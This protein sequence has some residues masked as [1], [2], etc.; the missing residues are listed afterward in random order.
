MAEETQS[1]VAPLAL[2]ELRR[3][4]ARRLWVNRLTRYVVG[5]GG[6]AV[7]GAI[8]LIF[9]YLLWVVAPVFGGATVDFER[10]L[11][12]TPEDRPL[13]LDVNEGGEIGL[14]I[15]ASGSVTFFDLTTAD[16]LLEFPLENPARAA[17]PVHQNETVYS[18]LDE[19]GLLWFVGASYVIEF[20]GDARSITPAPSFPFD[21]EPVELGD[22]IDFDVVLDDT[23]LV[24]ASLSSGRELVI[25]HYRDVEAGFPLD[26]PRRK[27][28][29][30][31]RRYASVYFG[32]RGKW[33]Y[34]LTEDGEIE[35][36][37]LKRPTSPKSVLFNRLAP[38][39]AEVTVMAPLLGRYSMLVGDNEGGITQ[40]FLVRDEF[41]YQFRAA[42]RF[43]TSAPALHIVPEPRRKGFIAIDADQRLYVFHTTSQ[44]ELAEVDLAE[45]APAM[46]GVISPR[47]NRLLLAERGAGIG[48]FQLHNE[49][50]EISW[51][52]LWA[53]VWY[54]GYEEPVFSWQ[55][56]SADND[57]EPKFS[58]T[59]LLF[60]TLKAALYAMLFAVPIAIMGALYTAYFMTAAMRRVVKPSIEIMAALPTVI[61]GFLAGLWLAPLVE[62]SLHSVIA[63][64]VVVPIGMLVFARLWTLLPETFTARFEGW[65]GALSVPVIVLLGWFAIE[66]GPILESAV[67]GGDTRAWFR[68]VLGL[69]YDQRNALIVGIAMG[70]AVIPVIFSLA[71]D[72]IYG[73]P[74]HLISGSLALGAT[75]WQT[76]M[77]V[78]ILTASPGIF[79]AVM[80][81]LGRAV[82]ETMI[83]LMATGNTPVMDLNIFQGMRTF[84]AN[85]AVELPESEVG[86]THYRILFLA[87]LV[88]FM[89]T[90]AFNTIAELVRQ[91]L[92]ARYGDL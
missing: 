17:K 45:R 55:S 30:L 26:L 9:F 59:P 37:D 10:Q 87:A 70:L 67:F 63:L 48:S 81:G 19:E 12:V 32:P 52:S 77:R 50:P 47:A 25:H 31:D 38:E 73:V 85:I 27:T 43:R 44:R 61:L 89:I 62:A 35:A 7:I 11:V 28:I 82:G 68:D 4:P 42:R 40:W 36:F 72:A 53:K 2:P 51:S 34:L 29:S 56:S 22:A 79:S 5:L 83:V 39:R 14:V 18:I 69:E 8:G 76:L 64:F 16:A 23:D 24:V 65:Y 58:L 54:E 6:A 3:L 86:S 60:G 13:L 15:N 20:D 84:A 46:F 78:V 21:E 41:G 57:F 74:Q 66:I 71:E 92:R 88:L 90:F 49:H 80:I 33:L 91:R 1:T 75:P